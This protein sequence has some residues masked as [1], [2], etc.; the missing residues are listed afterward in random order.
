[1]DVVILPQ[2]RARC[3][4]KVRQTQGVCPFLVAYR[5]GN[6]KWAQVFYNH[7]VLYMETALGVIDPVHCFLGVFFVLAPL[8]GF[9]SCL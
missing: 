9:K 3:D 7:H 8:V 6:L 5:V 2:W 4:R 1:M